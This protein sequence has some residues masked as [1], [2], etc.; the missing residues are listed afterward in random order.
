M[1]PPSSTFL[2]LSSFNQPYTHYYLLLPPYTTKESKEREGE[3]EGREG[4]VEEEGK[5]GREGRERGY[6]WDSNG[7]FYS[8]V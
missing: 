5:G 8:P 6:V 1:L 2:P 4:R 7:V 3:K